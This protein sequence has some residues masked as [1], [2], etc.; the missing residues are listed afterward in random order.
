MAQTKAMTTLENLPFMARATNA[1]VSY[2]VYL[3]QAICPVGLA[4]FYPHPRHSLS[5]W[6]LGGC[7]LLLIGISILVAVWRRGRPYL[8]MGWL[9]YLGMLVPVIGLVQVGEQAGADRYM[10]LPLIGPSLALAWITA[11]LAGSSSTRRSLFAA[12]WLLAIVCLID[13]AWRQASTWRDK[14]TLWTHAMNATSRNH[15]AYHNVA[16]ILAGRGQTDEAIR[17]YQAALEIKPDL[18]EAHYNLALVLA[19]RGQTDA[20]IARYRAALASNPDY[21]QAHNNLALALAEQGNIREA[22]AHYER[23]L[24][25]KPDYAQAHY[26][27]ALPLAGRGQVEEATTHYR[28]ALEIAPDFVQAHD[29]LGVALAGCGQLDDAIVHYRRALEIDPTFAQ[30]RMNLGNAL[31][32]RG[33]V[34]EAVAQYQKALAIEPRF[35]HAHYNLATALMSRGEVDEAI[36]H[37]REALA[38]K[39]AFGEAHQSL[40]SALAGRGRLDEAAVH[41]QKALEIKPDS[42][43]VR[44]NLAIVL[45]ARQKIA[46]SLEQKREAL[47]RQPGNA[48]LLSN[49]AWTL[50][51]NPNASIRNGAEALELALRATKLSDGREPAVLGTLAAAYAETGQFSEAVKT[52]EQAIRLAE[53]KGDRKLVEQIRGCLAFYKK[54]EPFRQTVGR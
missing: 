26:N 2:V 4:A 27:Y 36:A 5:A 48:A 17:H 1:A 54:G 46:E 32:A 47:R 19:S 45:S 42:S 6:T 22:M 41:L 34:D 24:A 20:A 39:P 37:L 53:A 49:T 30:S 15:L 50:A 23:A 44:R 16:L 21:A 9:W 13:L 43:D 10:Y 35:A 28:K 7:L 3:R 38:I 8:L 33:Q 11:D 29:N 51:T 12:A 40:A 14:E 52:A 25:I 31:V 18:A